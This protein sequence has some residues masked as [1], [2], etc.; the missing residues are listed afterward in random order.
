MIS[1]SHSSRRVDLS[2]PESRVQV[3][4]RA[5]FPEAVVRRSGNLV[6]RLAGWA[7]HLLRARR[8]TNHLKA[9]TQ[10]HPTIMRRW[11]RTGEWCQPITR[12]PRRFASGQTGS[13]IMRKFPAGDVSNERDCVI[14]TYATVR[15]ELAA[16]CLSG[17]F[18]K[19]QYVVVGFGL[20]AWKRPPASHLFIGRGLVP[21]PES[22]KGS[23]RRH[24]FLAPIM[25]K[26]EFIRKSLE[27]IAVHARLSETPGAAP[28]IPP[29]GAC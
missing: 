21:R 14:S 20:A 6:R 12:C 11:E 22:Q 29:L 3:D 9:K 19:P 24:R 16:S 28:H 23:E 4:R 7:P 17:C 8:F 5:A 18:S 10:L 25:T 27:M 13:A 1:L 15:R 2:P 26:D